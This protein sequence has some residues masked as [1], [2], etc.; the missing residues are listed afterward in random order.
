MKFI[1][2]Q[3]SS[4]PEAIIFDTDN[5]LYSF[6]NPN[7]YAMS[8]VSK[9]IVENFGIPEELF[10]YEFSKARQ[11]IKIR[12]GDT[13]SSHSRLLYFQVAL[14]RLGFGTRILETLDLE[15]TYWRSF[16]ESA[17]LFSGVE[18]FLT[19]LKNDGVKTANIT[20]LTSQIQFRKMVYFNL[21]NFFDYV[22]TSEESGVDK[23]S[24]LCF[25]IALDKM[26]IDNASNVWMIGDSYENDIVGAKNLGLKTFLKTNSPPK[27]MQKCDAYF[28]SYRKIIK[29]Y[30]TL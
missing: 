27:N 24:K 5:T 20:D 7:K 10:K 16:L 21:D 15:Q 17:S 13:A 4:K 22:V 18:E 9:K 19:I 1:T 12:L 23:P 3:F 6:N 8:K 25:E 14:E 30:E 26:D 11:Q 29:F 28:S 2:R